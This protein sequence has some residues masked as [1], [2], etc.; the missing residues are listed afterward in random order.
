M[1]NFFKKD[2]K[3][4]RDE[5]KKNKKVK[6]PAKVT[7]L[8]PFLDIEKDYIIQKNEVMDIIEIEGKDIFSLT[9]NELARD[10]NIFHT[11]YKTINIDIKL[12]SMNFPVNTQEQREYLEHKLKQTNNEIYKSFLMDKKAELEYLEGNRTNKEYYLFLFAPNV[13]ILNSAKNIVNRIIPNAL[14]TKNLSIEK[15]KWILYKLNNLNSKI[16]VRSEF[17][18]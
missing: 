9:E 11:L 18:E 12:V 6:V 3:E 14:N 4:A 7:N 13:E 10:I 17:I 8:L 16:D 2:N 5:V 1:I 15:K